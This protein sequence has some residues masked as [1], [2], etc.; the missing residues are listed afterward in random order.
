MT[1]PRILV[2]GPLAMIVMKSYDQYVN[3]RKSTVQ[4]YEVRKE[5][6]S[7]LLRNARKRLSVHGQCYVCQKPTYFETK[8]T[9]NPSSDQE[10]P[11]W[12]ES[13]ICK[14]CSLNNRLRAS[15]HVFHGLLKPSAEDPIYI[16]EQ[17]TPFFRLLKQ[18]YPS[19]IG[20]E[21]LGSDYPLGSTN[22]GGVRNESVVSLTFPD[23]SF[24]FVMTFDVLEHVPEYGRALVE[25]FRILTPGGTLLFTVPFDRGRTD[26]LTRAVVA[27]DGQIV[28]I[29]PP[30]YHGDPIN[31]SGCLSYY[32][33]GWDLIDRLD[34]VGFDDPKVLLYWSPPFG[35][36]GIE[37]MLLI[38]Y[39]KSAD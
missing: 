34:E 17:C 23:Q 9:R 33:F 18:R 21:F 7:G 1:F 13:L 11:N 19:V 36:L 8:V 6:E 39:K 26:T 14:N 20:S 4:E 16:T 37:Q 32:V 28:H 10:T 5:I 25:F 30:E 2:P 38:A 22:G 35:Y 24:K 27:E 15:Y 31:P 3:Y 12:R 29:L